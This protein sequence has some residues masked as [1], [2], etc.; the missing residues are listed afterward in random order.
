MLIGS[1]EGESEFVRWGWF[2][3]LNSSHM[4]SAK[5][6]Q[7]DVHRYNQAEDPHLKATKSYSHPFCG[8]GM[9]WRSQACTRWQFKVPFQRW[10]VYARRSNVIN[11]FTSLYGP[12]WL[13]HHATNG[14]CRYCSC[15]WTK[16]MKFS[17]F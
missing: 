8:G 1:G 5:Q 9:K 17:E 7:A 14:F 12:F 4:I 16:W 11:E 6:C 13:S 2:L 15:K 3:K 10:K